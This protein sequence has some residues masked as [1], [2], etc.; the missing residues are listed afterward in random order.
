MNRARG[1]LHV[2]HGHG[3]GTEHHA[4]AL[5]DASRTRYRHHL[6]I[7]VGDAWQVEEYLDDGSVA[8]VRS[9]TPTRRGMA[10]LRR[11]HLRVIRNRPHPSAQHLR[12]PRRHHRGARHARRALRLY[13]PRPQFRVP[14]AC[15]FS[16]PTA[17]TA[18]SRPIR[19]C[20]APAC[21]AAGVRAYRHRRLAR[22]ASRV[23]RAGVVPDRAVALGRRGAG[24]LLPGARGEVIPHGAPGARRVAV[25]GQP[26]GQR[27]SA[28]RALER[29]RY[30]T[31]SCRRSRYWA[32]W[33]PT[34]ARAGSS[35]WPTSSA[36]PA[37]PLRFVLIGYMDVQHG[38]WQSD[39]AC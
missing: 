3:G 26:T 21:G 14:D 5:I 37:A 10:R 28:A 33:V 30:P 8:H 36:R 1:V 6:A 12:L 19:P 20:A 13:G 34:R 4:R 29:S 22:A 38:P 24:A 31:M 11:R 2:I 18:T 17:T 25:R 27:T 23:A 39:D 15:C 7:A 9:P 16:A 35:A 32:R